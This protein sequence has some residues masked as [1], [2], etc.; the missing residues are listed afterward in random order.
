MDVGHG[1]VREDALSNLTAFRKIMDWIK[2]PFMLADG[3]LLGAYRDNGFVKDDENDIDIMIMDKYFG[4]WDEIKAKMIAKGFELTKEVDIQFANSLDSLTSG[5]TKTAEHHGGAFKRGKNHIDIM[6]MIPMGDKVCNYGDMG[7]L[8]YLYPEKLFE[9]F[10]KI[11]FY[12][13]KYGAP[14]DIDWFLTERYG[15]WRTPV[16]K[17]KYS[18]KDPKYSPNVRTTS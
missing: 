15:D 16:G 11:E 6:R 14:Y 12:G 3:T 17:D 8:I 13:V 1:T 2:V 5:Y 10:T 4:K 18:Y 7:R 9:K